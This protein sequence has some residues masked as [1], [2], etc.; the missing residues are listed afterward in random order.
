MHVNTFLFYLKKRKEKNFSSPK[1]TGHVGIHVSH[2]IIDIL[3]NILSITY[4]L[5]LHILSLT[6]VVRFLSMIHRIPKVNS[7]SVSTIKI[8][9]AVNP[10]FT[11]SFAKS[12]RLV[13]PISLT[14]KAILTFLDQKTIFKD[15]FETIS[16]LFF[17]VKNCYATGTALK[18][19]QATSQRL[20][21]FFSKRNTAHTK[22]ASKIG[23][24]LSF[25]VLCV[26]FEFNFF[27]FCI[28]QVSLKHSL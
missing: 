20:R 14:T 27:C 4:T 11:L 19:K 15:I 2:I 5:L 23:R 12:I 13:Q 22:N 18:K 8:Y 21:H 28:L 25:S 10:L 24:C 1:I 9:T 6:R 26:F 7:K 3:F 16:K 17:F